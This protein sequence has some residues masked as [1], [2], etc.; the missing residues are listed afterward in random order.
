MSYAQ[1]EAGE[2]EAAGREGERECGKV[3]MKEGGRQGEREDGRRK[4]K[5]ERERE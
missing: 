5:E 3:E 2:R 1:T 4:G